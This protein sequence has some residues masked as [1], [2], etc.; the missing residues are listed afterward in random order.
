MTIM[1]LAGSLAAAV[2]SSL[3]MFSAQGA[4]IVVAQAPS[5]STAPLAPPPPAAQRPAQPAP[6]QPPLQPYFPPA[7]PGTYPAPAPGA[8]PAA[9]PR[10]YPG[11]APGRYSQPAPA[12]PSPQ[13]SYPPSAAYPRPYY[14]APPDTR[15]S[16]L[17]YDP[18]KPIPP[19][20][21]LESYARKGFVIS[22]S[23]IFGI[24]YGIA[25]AVASSTTESSSYS[26]SSSPSYSSSGDDGVPFNNSLLY[27]PL[28]GPWLALGTVKENDCSSSGSYTYCSGNSSEVTVWRTLMVIGGVTQALGVGFVVLGLAARTH[29]LVLTEHV[30]A[31]VWPVPMGRSG[32]G[33]AMMGSFSGL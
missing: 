29:Q 1:R 20:Y 14:Y 16:V 22:G 27:V 23:I 4:P 15:P 13:Y 10:A 32:Q 7:A 18:D 31:S 8:Y 5:P 26:S 17:E 12:Y 2:L 33:L 28:L 30:R 11:P 3:L 21:H 19:G 24:S 25:L 6:G 9:A